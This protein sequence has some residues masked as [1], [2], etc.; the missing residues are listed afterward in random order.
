MA[1]PRNPVPNVR[2]LFT[3]APADVLALAALRARWGLASD[4]AVVRKI[5]REA[6][7]V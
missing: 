1:P 5:I 7:K 2:R 6:V 4:A 3:L